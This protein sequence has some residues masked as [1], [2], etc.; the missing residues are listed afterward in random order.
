M[1]GFFK[2]Q[3][4]LPTNSLSFPIFH[5]VIFP[6]PPFTFRD[7]MFTSF[8]MCNVLLF[9]CSSCELYLH[10]ERAQLCS[11]AA[12]HCKRASGELGLCLFSFFPSNI[13]KI[14][15][16]FSF[17]F[18][19]TKFTSF[20]SLALESSSIQQQCEISLM[21]QLSHYISGIPCPY[22]RNQQFMLL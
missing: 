22:A 18:S 15:I 20:I 13:T 1:T 2:C 14:Q 6:S 10:F 7:Y 21:L 3:Y 4:M 9:R 11:I 16:P 12:W 17:C 8:T 5:K 19:N